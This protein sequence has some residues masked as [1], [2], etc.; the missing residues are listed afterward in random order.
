MSRDDK[1]GRHGGE[2]VR[3]SLQLM[4][5]TS[6]EPTRGPKPGLS[7]ERIV[8]AAIEAADAEGLVAL[9]MRRIATTLGMGAMSLY[10]YVPSKAVLVDLMVDEVYREDLDAAAA[11]EGDWRTR[12][13]AFGRQ[14]WALYLRH[15]WLLQVAQGRPMFGPNSM[16]STDI[17]LHAVDGLGLTEDEMLGAVVMVSSFVAGLAKTTIE[18]TQAT[19][20]TGISDDEW[21][22]IQGEYVGP[23]VV[24]GKLP[25]LTKV[26]EAGA[27]TSMF[28]HFEFGLQR[29]LDGLG[30]LIQARYGKGP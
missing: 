2:G 8:R 24:A 29:V 22:E 30:L 28:D 9:S 21:W 6:E 23:A 17:V 11:V 27:F 10:R 25:M 14:E 13:E 15:P 4:W 12:L 3:R 19:E 5:G 20:R 7:V 26:G 16:R 1:A 18:A